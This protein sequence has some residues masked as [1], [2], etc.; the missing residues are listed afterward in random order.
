[1]RKISVGIMLLALALLVAVGSVDAATTGKINH[2][3]F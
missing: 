2:P 1:M 3:W